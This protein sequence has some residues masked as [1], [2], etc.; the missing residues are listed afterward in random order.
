M[1]LCL[2][3]ALTLVLSGIDVCLKYLIFCSCDHW[4]II[5]NTGDHICMRCW[6][7]RLKKF[8]NKSCVWLDLDIL[9]LTA[10][11]FTSKCQHR[12]QMFYRLF[13]CFNNCPE[14]IFSLYSWNSVIIFYRC[15]TV[16]VLFLCRANISQMQQEKKKVENIPRSRWQYWQSLCKDNRCRGRKYRKNM[17]C[18]IKIHF[19]FLVAAERL[20]CWAQ[21]HCVLSDCLVLDWK[22]VAFKSVS[23]SPTPIMFST[24]TR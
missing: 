22:R 11:M 7:T 4:P 13:P 18:L 19:Y 12:L 3:S 21:V 14:L 20:Y 9:F 5:V 2:C 8:K 16:N 6:K 23:V 1:C 17:T 24:W 10:E 15:F